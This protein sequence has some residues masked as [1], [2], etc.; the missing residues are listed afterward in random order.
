M[1]TPL[2]TA[3][4]IAKALPKH[5]RDGDGWKAC[6][7]AHDDKNPSLSIKDGDGGKILLFCYSGCEYKIIIDAV[8]RQHGIKL[9]N[10]GAGNDV[11]SRIMAPANWPST[12]RYCDENGIERYQVCRMYKENGDKT[13]RQ[14][15]PNGRGGYIPGIEGIERLPYQ[16]PKWK[17]INTVV[18]VEGEKDVDALMKYGIAATCNSGGAD[19][20]KSELNKWFAGKTVYIIP[21]NDKPG[22]KHAR[23][24]AEQ[25]EE[26]AAAVIISDICAGMKPKADVCDFII[27]HR[28]PSREELRAAITASTNASE[29]ICLSIDDWLSRKIPPMDFLLGELFSTTTRA[30]LAGPTGLG[31]TNFML[32]LTGAMSAGKN[33]LHWQS[34]RPARILYLDGELSRGWAKQLI[35]NMTD[36]LGLE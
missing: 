18:V 1:N 17:D 5:K 35:K 8:E 2:I 32:A 12:Y 31:K 27:E 19:N 6:C 21:D 7:P 16:L 34:K 29:E 9:G 24:V 11:A 36:R 20:W 23:K 15:K 4:Q 22:R 33:F 26:N 25:L 30:F 13:F 3:E 28:G 14:M 10:T